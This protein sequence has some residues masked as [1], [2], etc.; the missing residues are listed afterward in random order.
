[1]KSLYPGSAPDSEAMKAVPYY[2]PNTREAHVCFQRGETDS[3]F[4]RGRTLS[5]FP[6][7]LLGL[8]MWLV[9]HAGLAATIHVDSRV[10]ASGD[11]SSWSTAWKTIGEALSAASAGDEIWV[12]RGTYRE[13][14]TIARQVAVYG[15]FNGSETE[16]SQRPVGAHLTV[17]DASKADQG[18]A[19]EHVVAVTASQVRLDGFT[20][21]GGVA[22]EYYSGQGGGILCE[23]Y[24]AITVANC[25][26]VGNYAPKGGG[27]YAGYGTEITRSVI[28]GN[29][30]REG[31]GVYGYIVLTDTVISGNRALEYGGGI[32][33]RGTLRITNC[34]LQGNHAGEE[35]APPVYWRGA[36]GAAFVD[37]AEDVNVMNCA[38]LDNVCIENKGALHL[39]YAYQVN[40]VNI[41]NSIFCR[42]TGY[43]IFDYA[44]SMP[45]ERRITRCLFDGNSPAC[46]YDPGSGAEWS[47]AAEMNKNLPDAA[48]N[49][50]GD[51]KFAQSPT[52]TWTAPA[53][54]DPQE[55]RTTFTD[56]KAAFKP[57]ELAGRLMNLN[58]TT[59][60]AMGYV[61]SNT[62]T[63]VV[64]LGDVGYWSGPG[65]RI[66][67]WRL[68]DG[69]PALDRGTAV[70]APS[71]DF[72]G[73]IRPGADGLT[74]IGADEA[75]PSFTPPADTAPPV[76]RMAQLPALV[77]SSTFEIAWIA[78]DAESGIRN[79]RLYFQKDDG[80][81]TQYGDTLQTT[82]TLFDS[83]PTGGDGHYGFYALATDNSGLTESPSGDT[84]AATVVAATPLPPIQYV[85]SRVSASGNGASWS[86]ARKTISEA[87]SLSPHINEVRVAK[88]TYR[89]SIRMPRDT[90]LYG[91]FEGTE[92][93][94]AS[95]NPWG[96]PTILDA[97]A[98][99]HGKPGFH[100][101]TI[102][103]ATSVTLDGLIITGG[104]ATKLWPTD[105]DSVYRWSY[106]WGVNGGGIYLETGGPIAIRNC[107]IGGNSAK[108]WGGG[109]SAYHGFGGHADLTNCV[110]IGNSCDVV[111]G[112]YLGGSRSVIT[113]C[114]ICANQTDGLAVS[115]S[116]KVINSTICENRG[117]GLSCGWPYNFLYALKPEVTN[118]LLAGNSGYGASGN[119]SVMDSCLFWD[120]KQG[121][122]FTYVNNDYPPVAQ[123]LS[124]GYQIEKTI[125][126]ARRVREGDPKFVVGPGGTWTSTPVYDA[127]RNRTILTDTK[128]S[129]QPGMLVA[130]FVN[131][132][133]S[134]SSQAL[135]TSNTATMIEVSG[136]FH[137]TASAGGGYRLLDYHLRNGS[138]A[139]DR[140]TTETAP[141][142]DLEGRPRPGSDG[143]VDIGAYEAEDTW[144]HPTDM[145]SPMSEV[146]AGP[147]WVRI[148]VLNI[149]WFAWDA[150]SGL[151]SVELYYQ[152]NDGPWLRYGDPYTG[153]SVQFDTAQTGGDGEYRFYTVATDK[154][155]NREAVPAVPDRV[156]NVV[157]TPFKGT[158][159]VDGRVATSGY[160]Y[161]WAQAR[162]TITEALDMAYPGEEIW[163]AQG[164]YGESVQFK[165]NVR[166]YGG[167]A[168]NETLRSQRSRDPR[169]TIM[170]PSK[171]PADEKGFNHVVELRSVS[172]T[173]L[174]GFTITGAG[175]T[176]RFIYG[177]AAGIECV[178][179]DNSNT[180]S[181]CL[182]RDN[183]S[184]GY[185]YSDN[186][187]LYQS[188]IPGKGAGICCLD[189]SPVFTDCLITSNTAT[190]RGAGVYC[191][192]SSPTLRNCII[193]G[194]S[195]T[196]SNEALDE[197]DWT[198]TGQGGGI[199]CYSSDPVI[200]NCMIT[201]NTATDSGGG[202]FCEI[203]SPTLVN[204]VIS[205][206]TVRGKYW[207]YVS[208]DNWQGWIEL[209]I[210]R[211]GGIYCLNSSPVVSN[212]TITSNTALWGDAG[213]SC[214][215]RSRP[216]ITNTILSGNVGC[217]VVERDEAS[218]TVLS[219]CLFFGNTKGD[220]VVDGLTTYTGGAAINTHVPGARSNID[221]DPAFVDEAGGDYH[222]T[223]LSPCID[224]GR[225]T[226]PAEYGGVTTDFDGDARPSGPAY[227]IGADE[228]AAMEMGDHLYEAI[229]NRASTG[230]ERTAWR[231]IA[232]A[233][234]TTNINVGL[235][236]GKLAW[237]LFRSQ[238]YASRHRTNEEFIRD[239]YAAFLQR[240]PGPDELAAWLAGSWRREEALTIF[241]NSR[242]FADLV[243]KWFPASLGD[244]VRTFAASIYLGC[245]ERFPGG[246][247]LG[248][249]CGRLERYADKRG[250]VAELVSRLLT[251][252]EFLRPP[253][254]SDSR[255]LAKARVTALYR[256]LLGRFPGEQ[257]EAYWTE[258]LLSGRRS[259]Q[260]VIDGIAGSPECTARLRGVFQRPDPASAACWMLYP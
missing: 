83:S 28:L 85:D 237:D 147:A 84:G 168:G 238:E 46:Y 252:E 73:D 250:V 122:F 155:G 145:T 17:I 69:S 186:P 128:A 24:G 180:V 175:G 224:T 199:F 236:R 48:N 44:L 154:A 177:A 153:R 208:R 212:C 143:A 193:A 204:T 200:V 161:S 232:E 183:K 194:N 59:P 189:S 78:S 47:S 229:L 112:A 4:R 149:E 25:A 11:G 131:T 42:N 251:S 151:Q 80:L 188:W 187:D 227:D 170:D 225:D 123:A 253:A 120:N 77:T 68:Q 185:P 15:G 245:L 136:D 156:T 207:E 167:F 205:R 79:V 150:E 127:A 1:M 221:G 106:D 12:A 49:L 50:D 62:A 13:A 27:V 30:A 129:F 115:E 249:W 98:A 233:A 36:G 70:R 63:T 76:T 88:G 37:A 159:Y 181:N 257:E 137:Y 157:I 165:S 255:V 166:V 2:Q 64:L 94:L 142:S 179:A 213:L 72:E 126:A 33:S 81:W 6:A 174:D 162:K 32:R 135:I 138:Y 216:L 14:I 43:A 117:D 226:S 196:E 223:P 222:L 239:C 182:I 209:A 152:R 51:P 8:S 101:V 203:S 176:N 107:V 215:G 39:E 99:R 103:D 109:I 119:V 202:V 163:V 220:Y 91:G 96:N 95:R 34:I 241:W 26:I 22:R 108:I 217:A 144:T 71:T 121:D 19:A 97:S 133:A 244:P 197:W 40:R 243:A 184:L 7:I 146:L 45:Q 198:R 100:A 219:N 218:S 67:N 160:G 206:N 23:N 247:E 195:V 111:G 10:A 141:A 130:E 113:N 231:Q 82:S 164:T 210:G 90:A 105:S 9:C 60:V 75:D 259:L 260:M 92:T 192:R 114:V 29:Q 139:L 178:S 35:G 124:G 86:Q 41:V 256:S 258:E 234:E 56:D 125:P 140:G 31:G 74:D 190:D 52:G 158:L 93:S 66:V 18:M 102:L 254:R 87:L 38:F 21:T 169:L 110:I 20:I 201:D 132:A 228:F 16:L 89:E 171:A 116:S 5:L 248:E 65:Y 191:R 148:P 57:D 3:H 230:I 240:S 211:G 104:S 134:S 242:E 118:T 214:D 246:G 61:L 172:S 53:S 235:A 55:N 54:F 173:L 58:T